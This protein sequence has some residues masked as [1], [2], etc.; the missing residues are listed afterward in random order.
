MRNSLL[1]VVVV[2]GR[3]MRRGKVMRLGDL[4]RGLVVAQR[5]RRHRRGAGGR[6]VGG[7]HR[8]RPI[9][10]A[11]GVFQLPRRRN[12]L[13]NRIGRRVRERIR[14][15]SVRR[16]RILVVHG[17]RHL[18]GGRR[19]QRMLEVRLVRMDGRHVRVRMGQMS[20]RCSVQ[21]RR[22]LRGGRRRRAR[23]RTDGRRGGRT[24]GGHRLR[25]GQRRVTRMVGRRVR[26]FGR[27]RNTVSGNRRA[28][29]QFGRRIQTRRLER[30]RDSGRRR[31]Q[32]GGER[33]FFDVLDGYVGDERRIRIGSTGSRMRIDGRQRMR[34]TGGGGEQRLR[35]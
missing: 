11:F 26:Q 27:M 6:M 17:V 31:I 8:R 7:H 1:V 28:V 18:S 2:N 32:L 15:A 33:L 35:N 25:D 13:R 22:L 34:R 29:H 30:R 3:M 20:G 4:L 23:R 14:V 19:E 21:R 10:F 16:M 5:S 12:G 24:R 9:R